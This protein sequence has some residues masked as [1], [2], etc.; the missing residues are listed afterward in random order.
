M[1]ARGDFLEPSKFGH[2]RSLNFPIGK[3]PRMCMRVE[4]SFYML[5]FKYIGGL[6][7][8]DPTLAVAAKAAKAG[9]LEIFANLQGRPKGR[10]F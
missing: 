5:I 1:Y 10:C 3:N 2:F 7:P 8:M 9:I 4:I 6:Y